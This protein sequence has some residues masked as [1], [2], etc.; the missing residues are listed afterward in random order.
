M[1]C[2]ASSI[3]FKKKMGGRNPPIR[4]KL[5]RGPSGVGLSYERACK[6][7]KVIYVI[8][9]YQFCLKIPKHTLSFLYDYF[10]PFLT[11]QSICILVFNPILR[12]SENTYNL[13]DKMK[14]K[15]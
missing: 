2:T 8:N 9:P 7:K 3:T 1:L 15:K 6:M 10:L 13:I 5:A 14:V 12:Y 4:I 11:D